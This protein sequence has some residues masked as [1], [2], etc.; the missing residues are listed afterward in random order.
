M[1]YFKVY[2]QNCR[3]AKAYVPLTWEQFCNEIDE[4]IED[5]IPDV[6]NED[7]TL[8]YEATDMFTGT[9]F[10]EAEKE[11]EY[12]GLDCGDF[13]LYKRRDDF[14]MYDIARQNR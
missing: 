5:R 2:K 13:Y 12:N 1:K 3:V 7:G 11:T 8:D 9:L 4:C 14:D 6:E 10:Q